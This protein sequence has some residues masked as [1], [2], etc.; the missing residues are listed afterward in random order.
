MTLIPD[1]KQRRGALKSE[2]E[3]IL[4]RAELASRGLT[5]GETR[6]FD[7]SMASIREIDERIEQLGEQDVRESAAT[8]H[9]RLIGGGH[10]GGITTR[11][12]ETYAPDNY[13]HSFFDDLFTAQRGDASA[14]LRLAQNNDAVRETRAGD[15][16]T[17]AGAG[18]TFAPP[19]WLIDQFVALA[20]PGRVTADL[21]HREPMPMG[22]SSLN[23]PKISG[24]TATGVQ[25]TQNSALT[26]TAMT[27]TS[28]SSGI[29]LIGGKQIIS[30][31]LL[32]QSPGGSFDRIVLQDLAADYAKQLNQQVISGSGANG[33]LRGIAS[34]TGG[35]TITFTTASPKVVDGTTA[36]NSFYNVVIKAVTNVAQNRFAPA[37]A[38]IMRPDRWGW[39]LEALDTS[40]RP[41]VVP[42]GPVFNGLGISSE[43]VAAGAAGTLA[44]LPVYLDPLVPSTWNSSTNQDAVFVLRSS[45]MWLYESELELQVFSETYADNFSLLARALAYSAFLPDRQPASVGVIQG[46]GLT[47][48]SL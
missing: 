4:R 44:G 14:A 1:L 7:D 3:G 13:R 33:Q 16:T 46:S 23:L 5:S 36:A 12:R 38:I 25:A 32:D 47:A 10:S 11:T 17:V 34:V 20:R 9:R 31:Q 35:T 39:V 2:A 42:D 30:R 29:V 22:V 18:G 15:L 21:M 26:D 41:L 37:T 27:T 48:V 45:D 43:P 8:E 28:V 40:N 6:S 19:A 24:G